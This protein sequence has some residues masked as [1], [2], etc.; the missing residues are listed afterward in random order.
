MP[1]SSALTGA[2]LVQIGSDFGALAEQ[3]R[4]ILAD[5]NSNLSAGVSN[6][7]AADLS[8]LSN[9]AANLSMWGARI[10]FADSDASFQSISSATQSANA[11]V[12]RL[13][14]D[15]TK[16]GSIVNIL[17]SAVSL[18]VAFGTGNW[19]SVVSAAATL[20]SSISSAT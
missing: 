11:V 3:T 9:I 7:M 2:Q 5:P 15:E 6:A 14:G 16:I 8:S 17:G 18:G 10:V 1:A 13:K 4:S 12:A 20:G 19:V